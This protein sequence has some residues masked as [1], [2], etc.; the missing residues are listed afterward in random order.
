MNDSNKDKVSEFKEAIDS[1][2]EAD[3]EEL[4]KTMDDPNREWTPED[5][6]ILETANESYDRN[7]SYLVN[8][9]KN[10]KGIAKFFEKKEE[11]STELLKNKNS[12]AAKKEEIQALINQ[13]NERL[14]EL[15]A[16]ESTTKEDQEWQKQ[17]LKICQGLLD[18][19]LRLD[20]LYKQVE[21]L[22]IELDKHEKEIESRLSAKPLKENSTDD[23]HDGKLELNAKNI[24]RKMTFLEKKLRQ[25]D[26]TISVVFAAASFGFTKLF[27]TAYTLLDAIKTQLDNSAEMLTKATQHLEAFPVVNLV[28]GLSP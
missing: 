28:R 4:K 20:D 26:S 10:R 2:I 9:E 8:I 16:R 6:K 1:S 24:V 3:L 27:Q 15:N 14:A 17:A 18:K 7:L 25:L 23:K 5:K 13:Y 19:R 21:P 11:I 12:V 22:Q